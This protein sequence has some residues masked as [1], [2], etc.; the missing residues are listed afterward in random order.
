MFLSLLVFKLKILARERGR[1]RQ[2]LAEVTEY[3]LEQDD[4]GS[5]RRLAS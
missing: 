5:R 1:H 2:S 3:H 4:L